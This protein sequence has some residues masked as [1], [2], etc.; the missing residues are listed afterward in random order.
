[1]HA[2]RA[3]RGSTRLITATGCIG[4]MFGPRLP[5]Q[6][7]KVSIEVFRENTHYIQGQIRKRRFQSERSRLVR[8]PISDMSATTFI[9]REWPADP[10]LPSPLQTRVPHSSTDRCNPDKRTIT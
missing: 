8:C 1:M 5:V 6:A 7:V 3:C 10:T 4:A 2:C 9:E